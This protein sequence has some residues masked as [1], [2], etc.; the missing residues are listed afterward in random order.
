MGP[1]SLERDVGQPHGKG[2]PHFTQG[3]R[4]GGGQPARSENEGA[5]CSA[6]AGRDGASWSLAPG[7]MLLILRYLPWP[8]TLDIAACYTHRQMTRRDL[9]YNVHMHIH[10][11]KTGQS[12]SRW[13]CPAGCAGGCEVSVPWVEVLPQ[14]SSYITRAWNL[15][16][17]A[18]CYCRT[19]YM[20]L[21]EWCGGLQ[22]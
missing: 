10:I 22:S 13:R 20:V 9:G 15:G 7:F 17:A 5:D 16:L 21:L 12:A 18:Y 2:R 4:G 3:R 14:I 11:H 8:P 6:R 19:P 1:S